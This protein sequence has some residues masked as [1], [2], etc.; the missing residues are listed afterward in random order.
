[1][2]SRIDTLL[3][4]LKEI[5][6][7]NLIE[8]KT[9]H[10]DRKRHESDSE[11]SWHVAMFLILFQK[12]LTKNIDTLKTLKMILIHDLVEIYAGDT[13]LFDKKRRRTKVARERRAAK[14]L[15]SKLPKDLQKEF[16]DLFN[17]FE[18]GKTTESKIA[19]SLDKLQPVLQNMLSDGILWQKYKITES[20]IHQY[21]RHYMVH[22]PTIL[23]AYEKLV[24]EARKKKFI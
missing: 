3:D 14:K 9:L 12:D 5:E 23:L 8:R 1:M 21:K 13:F 24:E 11:H 17:E 18:S 22:D 19:K 4:F 10:S 2:P 7:M 15:F 20:L 6:K 16:T